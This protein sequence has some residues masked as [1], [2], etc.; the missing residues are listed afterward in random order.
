MPLNLRSH[1]SSSSSSSPPKIIIADWDETLT[2]K[3]T[4][5]YLAQVPYINNSKLQPPFSHYTQIYMSNYEAYKSQFG[6]CVTLDDHVRFQQGML[7]I[8]MSSVT[9]LEHDGIFR[10]LTKDQIRNQAAGHVELRPGAVD[11]LQ[12]CLVL[13]KQ[14]VILSV[15]WT[16]LIIEEVL[17]RNGIDNDRGVNGSKIKIITNEF[18]FKNEEESSLVD[19]QVS[20]SKLTPTSTTTGFWLPSPAIRTSSDK[21]T[22]IHQHHSPNGD[23]VMYIGD[24]LTDL[25]PSLNVSLPCAIKD[26]KLDQVLTQLEVDHFSGSWFDLI[27]LIE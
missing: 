4:I 18:E 14:V 11:F 15:N 22:Y 16:S 6:P 19:E 26:T 9:A 5:Q 8:E 2:T 17:K 27:K 25:L 1:S 3:D 12:R 21:L 24:S 10:G 13:D 20:G 7:P 23:E